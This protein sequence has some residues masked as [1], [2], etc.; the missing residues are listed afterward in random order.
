MHKQ[1]HGH[2]KERFHRRI[3]CGRGY[4]VKHFK[5]IY[6]AECDELFV[7]DL[8]SIACDECNTKW[9]KKEPELK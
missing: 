2:V 1:K 6:C 3:K 4:T 7:S 8:N 5:T 9:D